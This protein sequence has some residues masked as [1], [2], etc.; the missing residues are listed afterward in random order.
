LNIAFVVANLEFDFMG[1][2][3][4]FRRV[5]VERMLPYLSVESTDQESQRKRL[6]LFQMVFVIVIPI[7]NVAEII[8]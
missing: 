8:L 4:S 1:V 2:S 6:H 5:H 3:H 7:I